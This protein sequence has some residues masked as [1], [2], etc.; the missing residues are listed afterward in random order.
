VAGSMSNVKMLT[1]SSLPCNSMVKYSDESVHE[2]H[3]L[4]GENSMVQIRLYKIFF[5]VVG[6][7]LPCVV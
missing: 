1:M 6:Q 4:S 5:W 2:S 7:I 3:A